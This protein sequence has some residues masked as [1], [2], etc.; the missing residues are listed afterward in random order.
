M[1]KH[2]INVL[3]IIGPHIYFPVYSNGLKEIAGVLGHK[4]SAANASGAQ[5]VLW[6]RRWDETQDPHIKGE[7]V[8]Y[9]MEVT[10]RIVSR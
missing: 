5:A 2:A 9:N 6:R 1:L 8:R 3:A 10:W 7:L 4:W